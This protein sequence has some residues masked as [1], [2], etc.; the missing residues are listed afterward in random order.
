M[1]SGRNT[2][3]LIVGELP[4]RDVL[5]DRVYRQSARF[6]ELCGDYRRCAAALERWH[7]SDD[8]ASPARESEYAELLDQLR[9]EIVQWLDAMDAG[10]TPPQQRGLR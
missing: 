7:R 5:I 3:S 4:D 8:A 10:S 2:L 9:G 6:R 1:T